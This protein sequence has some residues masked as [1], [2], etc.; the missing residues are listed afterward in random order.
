MRLKR[1]GVAVT[2]ERRMVRRV[3]TNSN[4]GDLL[5]GKQEEED[6]G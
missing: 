2:K 1:A 6:R 5:M 3:P 4:L